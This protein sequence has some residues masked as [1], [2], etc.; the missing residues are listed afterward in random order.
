MLGTVTLIAGIAIGLG[1][2][3]L[4]L[5]L[6]LGVVNA[7]IGVH[8]PAGRAASLRARGMYWR[9]FAFSLPVQIAFIALLYGLGYGIAWLVG[10]A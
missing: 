4:W 2:M 7:F 10:M 3:P 8:H 6:P 1:Q 5:V 9:V